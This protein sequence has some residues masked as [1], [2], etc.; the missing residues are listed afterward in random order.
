M[1]QNATAE[2][3]D[4]FGPYG[5]LFPSTTVITHAGYSATYVARVNCARNRGLPEFFSGLQLAYPV[6]KSWHRPRR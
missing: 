2:S 1:S 5:S 4:T 3:S 6:K